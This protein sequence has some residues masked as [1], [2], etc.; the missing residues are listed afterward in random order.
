MNPLVAP[1]GPYSEIYEEGILK[2]ILGQMLQLLR[3]CL[4]RFNLFDMMS[5]KIKYVRAVFGRGIS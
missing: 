3:Q 1:S 5:V 2:S 4:D